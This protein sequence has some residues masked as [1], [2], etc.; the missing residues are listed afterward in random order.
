MSSGKL[1]AQVA[2]AVVNC[3]SDADF[4]FDPRDRIIVVLGVS[5]T[6]FKNTITELHD[7][8]I[9]DMYIQKDLGFTEVEA[10]TQTAV[11]WVEEK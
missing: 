8:N 10:G 2:H 11:A 4:E 1:A 5:A 7:N 6:K 3:P 9:D